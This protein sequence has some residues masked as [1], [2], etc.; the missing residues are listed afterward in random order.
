MLNLKKGVIEIIYRELIE[1]VESRL[2]EL[3][4]SFVQILQPMYSEKCRTFD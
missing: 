4:F 3:N 1:N 2:F